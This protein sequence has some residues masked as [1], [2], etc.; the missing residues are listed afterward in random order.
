MLKVCVNGARRPV[1]HP[2]LFREPRLIAEEARAAVDAG[3]G[4]IHLH[5]KDLTGHDSLSGIYVDR[6]MSAMRTASPDVPIG[7]TSGEWAAPSVADR[8]A[9]IRTWAILPDFVSV[10]W[11]E[12]GADE[13]AGLLIERGIGIEAG[14]WNT[15]GLQCW[16]ESPHRS[17]C[18]RAL[19]ELPDIEGDEEIKDAA[20]A[21]IDGVKNAELELSILLHGEE[22]STWP[23]LALADEWGL[24][25][26]IGLED[27]LLLPD[28]TRAKGNQELVEAALDRPQIAIVDGGAVFTA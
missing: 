5:P 2:R 8:L 28:G 20:A 27:T 23:A 25:S 18:L 22:R 6:F 14:I 10:N 4:A 13:V 16:T 9:A 24:D 12:E 17:G 1:E 7:I 3:A 15:T 21:L 11:H 26:R 19:I